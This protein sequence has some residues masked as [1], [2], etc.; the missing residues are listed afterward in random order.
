MST[1]EKPSFTT[2]SFAESLKDLLRWRRDVRR[3]QTTPIPDAEILRLLEIAHLSPSVG[4]CQPWRFVRVRS[5]AAR[6]ALRANFLHCNAEALAGFQGEDAALYATLKLSGLDDAPVQL[7]VFSDAGTSAGRG[8]GRRTMPQAADYS[9]VIAIHTLWLAARA[10]GIG[11]GWVSIL[12]PA[13]VSV[14]LHMPKDLHLIAYLCL[15]LPVEEHLDPE[16]Q[17]AGWEQ[18]RPLG[19]FLE[20]R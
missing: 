17:R 12:D 10:S 14:S 9:V 8:L 19:E 2:P 6:A 11:M 13:A 18:R 5:P 3:F 15:G 4:L 20:E 1:P 7:A 16:L